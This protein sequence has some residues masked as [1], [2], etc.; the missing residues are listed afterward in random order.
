M[1]AARVGRFSTAAV[2]CAATLLMGGC[3]GDDTKD[4]PTSDPSGNASGGDQVP[5]QATVGKVHGRLKP[6]AAKAAVNGISPVVDGWF[7][8]AYLDGDYPRTDFADSFPGFTP[9]A[10]QDAKQ[11]SGLMTNK[12][13]GGDVDGVAA[14]L[15]QVEV[16]LLA[17]NHKAAGATARFTLVF[18]TTGDYAKEVSVKGR[19]FLTRGSEGKWRVFGY[20]VTRSAK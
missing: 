10:A 18:T 15:K 20:N 9:G 8:A 14:D 1:N 6:S 19:L 12:Q 5:M 11:D 17:A 16:D 13:V 2:V 7:K 4:D 3:S